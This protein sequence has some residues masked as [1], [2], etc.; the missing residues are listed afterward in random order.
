MDRRESEYG[1]MIRFGTVQAVFP[2]RSGPH[3]GIPIRPADRSLAA[4]TMVSDPSRGLS[5]R[6]YG[7]VD[8]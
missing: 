4:E 8:N 6:L 7:T 3:P 5:S 1:W 2:R